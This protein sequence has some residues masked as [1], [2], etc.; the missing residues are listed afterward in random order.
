MRLPSIRY[1]FPDYNTCRSPSTVLQSRAHLEQQL[2]D[3]AARGM[4]VTHPLHHDCAY[5]RMVIQKSPAAAI[6]TPPMMRNA[7]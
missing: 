5:C 3:R 7:C 6:W 2:T 1:P 4:R